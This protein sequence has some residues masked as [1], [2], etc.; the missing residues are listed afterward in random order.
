MTDDDRRKR[1]RTRRLQED[2]REVV[3]HSVRCGP[4]G[5]GGTGIGLRVSRDL[6]AGD[7]RLVSARRGRGI[8]AAEGPP[9]ECQGCEAMNGHNGE[10][11]FAAE[12]LTGAG[13][14]YL[15][16]SLSACRV[17]GLEGRPR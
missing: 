8:R 14:V 17:S 6:E 9:G 5:P 15:S 4:L 1:P 3:D 10:T 13:M 7:R 12:S 2:S 16:G 11:G